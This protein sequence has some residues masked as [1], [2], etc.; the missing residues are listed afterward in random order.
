MTSSRREQPQR[1]PRG[2]TGEACLSPTLPR[3]LHPTSQRPTTGGRAWETAHIRDHHRQFRGHH[4]GMSDPFVHGVPEFTAPPGRCGNRPLRPEC[5]LM[6]LRVMPVSVARDNGRGMAFAPTLPRDL[7]PGLRPPTPPGRCGNRPL[8]PECE[9]V[10]LRVMPVSVARDYGRDMSLPYKY[11][12][13]HATG[14]FGRLTS[15]IA[16]IATTARSTAAMVKAATY[17]PKASYIMPENRG[18]VAVP[19]LCARFSAPNTAP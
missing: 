15:R 17:D 5:E 11:T 18:P 4:R 19:V 8:R 10:K 9:L 1:S 16:G 13:S 12:E 2:T 14:S 3:D 6:K 7:R